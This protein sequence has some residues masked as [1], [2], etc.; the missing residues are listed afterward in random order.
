MMQAAE[1]IQKLF[2]EGVSFMMTSILKN[3]KKKTK[4]K[5]S[6]SVH[7]RIICGTVLNMGVWRYSWPIVERSNL[8]K[9]ISE[10]QTRIELATF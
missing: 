1:F 3:G 4:L 9:A 8:T 2:P 10:P 5:A 6:E 7:D